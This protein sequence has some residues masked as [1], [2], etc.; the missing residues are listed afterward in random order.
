[1]ERP[2]LSGTASF[3]NGTVRALDFTPNVPVFA[4]ITNAA[5]NTGITS[6]QVTLTGFTDAV[7]ISITGGEYS[8]DSE[9]VALPAIDAASTARWIEAVLAGEARM[10]PSLART[11][12]EVIMIW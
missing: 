1:M 9:S 7:P 8:I 3:T 11:T 5:L 4:P 10:P 12:P 2:R 6:A